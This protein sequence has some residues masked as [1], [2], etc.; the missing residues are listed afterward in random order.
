VAAPFEIGPASTWTARISAQGACP[1]RPSREKSDYVKNAGTYDVMAGVFG[2]IALA[3]SI[4]QF[5]YV[6]FAFAPLALLALVI[7]I[8]ASPKYRGLY[9][10][11]AVVLVVGFVVGAS[12][13]V[14]ADKP[15]Y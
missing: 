15:L 1:L 3:A 12:V 4:V 13:A 5:F 10:L 7:A 8:M 2:V 6:P 9:E 14:I 11:T